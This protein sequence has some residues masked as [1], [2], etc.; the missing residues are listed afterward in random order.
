MVKLLNG[1]KYFV[2]V[3]RLQ[4]DVSLQ[5]TCLQDELYICDIVVLLSAYGFLKL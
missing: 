5:N 4:T 2:S 1:M 3:H